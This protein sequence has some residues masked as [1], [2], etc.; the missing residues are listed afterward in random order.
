MCDRLQS[1]PDDLRR[2]KPKKFL[3]FCENKRTMS[4]CLDEGEKRVRKQARQRERQAADN[5]FDRVAAVYLAADNADLG[6]I[7]LNQNRTV[8]KRST[9]KGRERAQR[10]LAANDVKKFA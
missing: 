9:E 7:F 2:I 4:S 6:S 3:T 1:V 10:R 8:A 5:S